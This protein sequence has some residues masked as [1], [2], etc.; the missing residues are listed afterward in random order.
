LKYG[1]AEGFEIVGGGFALS[2]PKYYERFRDVCL[3]MMREQGVNQFK[4]DGTGNV[5]HVVPG[6]RFDSDFDAMIHLIGELRTAK[7][8]IYINLTTGT[9]ASPFWLRYADS[10]WRGG[11]DDALTGVGTKRER[12]IT[13][14]DA[15]T[16][17]RVVARGPLFPLNSL[18]LHG[19]I[20]ARYNP[21]LKD[22]PGDDFANE[23]R[24][25]FG[26]G[27]QLQEM[28]LTPELLSK[29]NWDVLAEAARWSRK[30]AEVLKDTHWVG[31]DPDWLQVYGWASWSKEKSILV[32]RNPSDKPQEITLDL[33]TVLELPTGAARRFKARSPWE[34][35][36][37]KSAISLVAGTPHRFALKPF[38]VLTLDLQ[39]LR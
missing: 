36:A 35:D 38:E 27:T 9:T 22:D 17:E 12:W 23:V 10:I 6:S 26:T 1:E 3:K 37:G 28:Y 32:L 18:M 25:Y 15:Q 5:N 29:K 24:S 14:R 19:I 34:E 39:P 4:F 31:G 13:Y 33:A 20:Y 11:E 8:D 21:R 2:G 30:N 7:P 16:Y